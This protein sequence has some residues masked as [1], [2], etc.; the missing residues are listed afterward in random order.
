[1][2]IADALPGNVVACAGIGVGS[3]ESAALVLSRLSTAKLPDLL[4]SGQDSKPEDMERLLNLLQSAQNRHKEV[5]DPVEVLAAFGGFEI[6]MMVGLML[7]AGSKRHLLII[8]GLRPARQVLI[9]SRIAP[10]VGDYSVFTRS[11]CHK[12]GWTTRWLFLARRRCSSWAWKALT[13]PAPRWPG[14]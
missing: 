10:A 11:H 13:A 12:P 5:S 6:A 3:H 9:A 2:E 1:M 8:D 14:R 4:K 7:V